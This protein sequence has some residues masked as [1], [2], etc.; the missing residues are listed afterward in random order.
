[1]FYLAILLGALLVYIIQGKVYDKRTRSRLSYLV[2]AGAEE[3]FE[4]EDV[5]FYGEVA[6]D[7]ALPL[8]FLKVN[9]D[10]PEGLY[11]HFVD[12]VTDP[13]T[14]ETVMRDTYEGQVQSIYVL[15]SYQ[16]ISRRWRVTCKKRGVY[17][18]GDALLLTNDLFGLNGNSFSAS[19][20][21]GFQPY[22]LTVLPKSIDLSTHFVAADGMTGDVITNHSLLTDPLIRAGTREYRSDDPQRSINWKSTAAHGRLM[23]NIEEHYRRFVFNIVLNMQSRPIEK[24]KDVPS[25]P[26][27]I[28]RCISIAATLLDR[29]SD[30]SVPT[31]VILNTNRKSIK[32]DD[33]TVVSPI[34]PGD[35]VGGKIVMSRSY[36]GRMQTLDALRLLAGIPME[37]SVPEENLL[38]HII[39]NP[40]LYTEAADHMGAA[41]LVFVSS[42]FSERMIHF[43]R[44]ME[45]RGVRVIYYI[46]SAN[47]NAL[48]I[49]DDIEIYFSVG[50]ILTD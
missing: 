11:F 5:Y 9:D 14:G 37:I 32:L 24:Y 21:P 25:A 36:E 50:S 43:H 38:D 13:K 34:D 3:V 8:P 12:P 29:A 40:A 39:A 46:A 17:D 41:N 44:A 1:M 31:R 45:E 6:N 4:D 42:Y 20:L 26:H 7:K 23:V 15:E 49:P 10:L 35:A 47:R 18:L 48:T 30:G 28:E 33:P 19:S 27:E 16:K 22:H 2:R